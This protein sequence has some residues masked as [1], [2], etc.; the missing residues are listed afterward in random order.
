MQ[1]V[2]EQIAQL[3]QKAEDADST[4]LQDDL[5]ISGEIQRREDRIAK[6]REATQVMEARAKERLL[7]EQ[8]A[9]REKL[10]A[11]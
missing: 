3:L 11:C 7:E 4:R 10:A 5:T 8:A 9:Y 1:L 6:L 2:E